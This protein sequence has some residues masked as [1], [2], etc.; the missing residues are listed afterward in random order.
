[1]CP[2]KVVKQRGGEKD[3]TLVLGILLKRETIEVKYKS[4]IKTT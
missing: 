3:I 1:M 4:S 2:K